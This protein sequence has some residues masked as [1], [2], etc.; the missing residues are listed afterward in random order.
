M[1][2]HENPE[3][4]KYNNSTTKT[5]EA[6]CAIHRKLERMQN[7]KRLFAFGQILISSVVSPT[8]HTKCT[9]TQ[10]TREFSA[11]LLIL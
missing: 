10:L 8:I 4:R 2:W 1:K 9:F 11:S 6:I 5:N 7:L 3:E